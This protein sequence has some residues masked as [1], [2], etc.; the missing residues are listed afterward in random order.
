MVQGVL[1]RGTR[2]HTGARSIAAWGRAREGVRR[3]HA[4]IATSAATVAASRCPWGCARTS[5][6]A[7]STGAAAVVAL[8]AVGSIG[9]EPARVTL[10]LLRTS[11]AAASA[12]SAAALVAAVTTAAAAAAAPAAATS[13]TAPAAAAAAGPALT[14]AS[15]T[16][17]PLPSAARQ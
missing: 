13:P 8:D 15:S 7:A 11:T 4:A 17:L 5:V 2:W 16:L 1:A 10:P 6:T 9:V 12:A 14:S 3:E